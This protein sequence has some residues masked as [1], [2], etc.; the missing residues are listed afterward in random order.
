MNIEQ[1]DGRDHQARTSDHPFQDHAQAG[2]RVHRM[3]T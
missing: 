3:I 1:D 2:L